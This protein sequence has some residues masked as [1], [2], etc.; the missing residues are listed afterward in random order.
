MVLVVIF[1]DLVGGAGVVVIRKIVDV[2]F[3]D[4][5]IG[6]TIIVVDV[7]DGFVLF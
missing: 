2:R 7:V 1:S 4:V 3:I 5:W 6:G